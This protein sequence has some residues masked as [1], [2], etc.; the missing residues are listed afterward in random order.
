MSAPLTLITGANGA[1]GF[2]VVLH[3]LKANY[4]VRAVVRSQEKADLILSAASIKSLPESIQARLTFAFVPDLLS[5]SAY[6]DAIQGVTHVIHL[7]SPIPTGGKIG[8]NDF[9]EKMIQPAIKGTLNLLE[10]AERAHIKR[11]VVTSS[12]AAVVA[13]E[14]WLR[15]GN[16]NVY[17]ETSRVDDPVGPYGNESEAYRASKIL[18]LNAAER[19]AKNGGQGRTVEVVH[20]HPA[21]V[22]GSVELART[23]QDLL[24]GSSGTA[25]M[26]ILSEKPFPRPLTSITAW[27]EDVAEV[28]VRA[29]DNSRIPNGQSL[30]VSSDGIHG[31]RWKDGEN[32]LA[33]EFAKA[34]EK[35]VLPNKGWAGTA[36][37][38]FDVSKTER[39][40]GV[41]FTGFEK[42]I[43]DVAGQYL[44][45]IGE[46][47]G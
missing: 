6:D 45:I 20:V 14:D 11:V 42:Q 16:D 36:T 43:V 9:D 19:W 40:V 41:K 5:P 8:P 28:H 33:R 1:I 3:A 4:N 27:L 12:V 46:Q 37:L 30:I 22:L 39:L 15:E 47:R 35:G 21:F 26:Q 24:S 13:V 23:K 10:A 31:M 17:T 29:L 32:I 38:K 44:D 2:P 34:V 25:L 18:A 7:A